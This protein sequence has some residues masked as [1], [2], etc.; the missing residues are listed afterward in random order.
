MGRKHN[1]SSRNSYH[2]Q[3]PLSLKAYGGRGAG[4][5]SDEEE[6]KD[7]DKDY[8]DRCRTL[9]NPFLR[10]GKASMRSRNTAFELPPLRNTFPIPKID[11]LLIPY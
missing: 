2:A 3:N 11:V 9:V 7:K 8:T 4:A 6:A 5:E 10:R 1:L